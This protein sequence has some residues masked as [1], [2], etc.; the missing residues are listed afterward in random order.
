MTHCHKL[1]LYNMLS[2][3]VIPSTHSEAKSPFRK[4]GIHCFN[5]L[6]NTRLRGYDSWN[7][8]VWVIYF[9]KSYPLQNWTYI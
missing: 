4:T 1:I 8:S 5:T 3:I 9:S 7:R 2:H 6:L